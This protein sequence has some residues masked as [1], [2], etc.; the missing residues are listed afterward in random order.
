[1]Q[2]VADLHTHTVASGHAFSTVKEMAEAAAQQGLHM[3]AITDHGLAMPG[4]PHKYYFEN[5]TFCPRF[6]FG[7]EILRGVEANI[8]DY[9]GNLDMPPELLD[10][11]DIVLAGFHDAT[12]YKK[13]GI[14]ENTKA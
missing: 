2:I 6:M 11:M 13:G 8:I 4:A 14:E 12:G 10:R 9:D 1:M 5:L 7:V 3:L